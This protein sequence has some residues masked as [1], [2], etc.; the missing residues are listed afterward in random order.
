MIQ[1]A[2]DLDI[3]DEVFAHPLMKGISDAAI[4]LMAWPNVCVLSVT[5]GIY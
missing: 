5:L 1:Y 4:D 3:P 2:L